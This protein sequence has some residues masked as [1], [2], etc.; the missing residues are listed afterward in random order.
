M[1]LAGRFGHTGRA[2]RSAVLL[3]LAAAAFAA[4]LVVWHEPGPIAG[5]VTRVAEGVAAGYPVGEFAVTLRTG[6]GGDPSDDV[7]SVAHGSDPDRV[8]WKTIPGESFVSAARGE[9]TVHESSGHFTIED[10]VE[11]IHRDQ[12]IDGV[13]RRGEAL[14]I[15]GRLVGGGDEVGYA[16]TFSPVTG[17]RL[18]FEVEVE[19]PYDRV[20]LTYASA[21]EERFFGFGVQYTHLDLKGHKVPIFIQEGGI[22]RGAQPITLAADWRAGA[23]GDPYASYASVPH[24]VTSEMRSLFLENYEYSSFD[25]REDDRVQVEVFSSRMRGQILSGET[26][27]ELIEQYTEYS[28]RMSPLPRW[29]LGGAVVGVQGGTDRV[30]DLHGRLEALDAPVAAFWLQDWVGQRETSFGTQLWWNWELDEDRYPGWEGLREGLDEKGV[31][32]MT[33]VNPFLAD[34]VAEKGDRSRALFEEAGR[35]GYLVED[36]DGE[37]YRIPGTDFSAGLVDLSNPEARA[38][39]EGVIRDELL[40]NGASGWMA[41]F[42]EGLPYDAV[43]YSGADPRYYHNRYAEEW[44]EVNREAIRE[45]GREGEVVFFNRSGYTRSPEHATLFWLGDQLVSWDEHDGIKSA[46]TGLLSSGLSGYA[47]EHSDIGGYTAIESPVLRYHRSEELLMR[48][49][50]LAAFTVV[51][52]T[53]EG[54]RPEVNHQV[55]SDEAALR[56]FARLARVYAAWRP[57]RTELVGEAAET[58]LPVVR[59]PFV[60]YPE[61]PEAYGLE[62]Q[63]MVGEDLMVAPVLDPGERDVEV[64]LP[65]GRWVHLWSGRGYGSAERGVYETVQAPLGE[66]AVFYKKGSQAGK[67]FRDELEARGLLRPA[68]SP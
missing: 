43:L 9:E 6:H 18:R 66:P 7:L 49:A 44:A 41:D 37:P 67:N 64:Y 65:A 59:H 29:I 42:G 4:A 60:H 11:E 40:G 58:G 12:T 63:F 53:H 46:V 14:V 56:H 68:S 1:G 38:W 33:Y 16:L 24:Y 2:A 17:E 25:L 35:K 57:Y 51:F 8:L 27:P 62:Y 30:S 31:R 5:S 34:D 3:I 48:W 39:M 20:Y 15:S 54:N 61:D 26:P 55:Y 36:R 47:F 28:G 50:E 22:G 10:E 21:P 23:G 52:R 13:E 45:A 19:E 32:L